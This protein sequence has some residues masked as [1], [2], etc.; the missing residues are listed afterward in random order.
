M[1]KPRVL[2]LVDRTR[3]EV[4]DVVEE[5]RAGVP[6]HAQIVSEVETTHE[7]MPA[8]LRADLAVVLGEDGTLLSQARPMIRSS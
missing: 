3:Q 2:L 7:P 6:E 8:D 1:A 4:L 5:V